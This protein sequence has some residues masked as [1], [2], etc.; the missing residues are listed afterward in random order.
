MRRLLVVLVLLGAALIGL[1]RLAVVAAERAVAKKLQTDQGLAV[2]PDVRIG[3]FPFLTQV[4]AGDYRDVSASV[5]G[6][7]RGG[8]TVTRVTARLHGVHLSMTELVRRSTHR[9]RAD[10][11]DGEVLLSYADVDAYLS[12]QGLWVAEGTGGRVR[13]STVGGQVLVEAPPR[14]VGEDVV[15]DAGRVTVALHLPQ[16]PFGVRLTAVR[17]TADGLLVAATARDLVV[18]TG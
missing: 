14:V 5:S 6:L 12:G 11:A 17:A 2:P 16:L 4:L 15:F 10:R 1:D 8:L 7:R 18:P 3:G 13:V 9:L